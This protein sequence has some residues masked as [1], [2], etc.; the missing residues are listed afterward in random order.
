MSEDLGYGWQGDLVDLSAYLERVGYDGDVA[1]TVATLCALH[2]AHTTSIPFENLEVMLGRP[3][4]LALDAIQAKLVG[5]PRGGYCFEHTRLFAAVLERLGYE[6][7]A[8]AG[9]VT[10]GARK[11]LPS[12]HALLHVRPPGQPRDEPAWLCDVGFGSGPLEPLRFLD[13]E[14][15]DQDGWGFR[16]QQGRTVSAWSPNTV[17]WEL[18]QRGPDGWVQRHTFAMNEVFRIDF[19][20][21]NYFVST[22]PH[23]PFTTRPFVQKFTGDA[24]YVLDGTN[25]SVTYPDGPV[26]RYA[27]GVDDLPDVLAK[28]FGIVLDDADIP[29][30][31]DFMRTHQKE[32]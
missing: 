10:L 6:V 12:T 28:D 15:V 17:G 1:P 4:D 16:L 8:L 27:H 11:I 31:T 14:E 5:R 29:R 32:S 7:I 13:G 2:R 3:V 25:E 21:F 18:H 22:S 23:S 19:E 20:L 24:L 30:L 26:K 9:R